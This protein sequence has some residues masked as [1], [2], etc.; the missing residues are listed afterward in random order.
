MLI[1]DIR[2]ALR[3]KGASAAV[4]YAAAAT[5]TAA[6]AAK[7]LS[8]DDREQKAKLLLYVDRAI[9]LKGKRVRAHRLT[10]RLRCSN[11]KPL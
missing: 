1:K 3:E 4:A 10:P 7:R 5:A 6:A 9:A 8:S 11:P 2:A